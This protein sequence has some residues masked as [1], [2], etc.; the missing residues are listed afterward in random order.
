[1]K[2]KKISRFD[3]ADFNS[4]E[5]IVDAI[6]RL[7]PDLPIPVPVDELALMLDIISIEDEDFE[8][9]EGT[10]LLNDIEKSAGIIGVKRTNPVQRQRRRFTIG[11]ELC[12]FLAPSHKPLSGIQ[13]E[14]SADDMHLSFGRKEGPAA[15]ME[16]EANR[17]A[18]RL[19]M[20]ELYFRKD[21]RLR[22]GAEIEHI[23][24][25]AERY[26]TSKEATARRYV[27]LQDEPC[28]I[29]VSHNG[30][31]LRPYRHEDFPFMDVERGDPVPRGSM[32]ARTDL[33]QGIPSDPEERDGGI[34][35]SVKSGRRAPRLYEQVLSQ[36]DK[37]RLTLLSLA[38]DHEEL[39]E[40]EDL[41]ESYTPRF[42]R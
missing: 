35:L 30:R 20:P 14:C 10:L 29:I 39:E 13:F 41:E 23:L 26:D 31:I 17:F 5:R 40:D 6:I 7:I 4:P 12:H 28:A 33:K 27:D 18:A 22:K 1:M 38:D 9:F 24:A 34:W 32:T 3:L 19:L 16:V 36:S 2:V 25:L 11:H 21:L 37:Y 42:R 15:H 8:G